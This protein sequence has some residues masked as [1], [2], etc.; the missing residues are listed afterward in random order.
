MTAIENLS[1]KRKNII[2]VGLTLSVLLAALDSTVVSTAMK[3]ISD[4]L[5]GLDLYTWPLTIYMLFSTIITPI[6]GK[7]ADTFGR[8]FFFMIGAVTFLGASAL[9]GVSQTMMQLIVFRG[10]QG[11][12]GGILMS[13]TFAMI[14]DIFPPEE[15]AKNTGIVFSAFGLASVIGPALGGTL[16]DHLG[17]RWVFYVN[18]PVGII[19]IAII[20]ATVPS[21]KHIHAARSKIDYMGTI[22]LVLGLTPMLFAFMW[23]GDKY[24]WSSVQIISLFAFSAALLVIFGL[25]EN[26]AKDPIIS[27]SLFKDRT[28]RISTASVFLSNATMLGAV[29]FIPLYVQVVL[30][31]SAT[32]SGMAELPM[33]LGFVVASFISGQAISKTGKLKVFGVAGFV[34]T[35]VGILILTV[36]GANSPFAMLVIGMLIAGVGIGINMP[37]FTLAVQNVF[38]QSKMGVVTAAVQFFRSIGGTIASAVFGT[39]MLSSI[40]SGLSKIDFLALTSS[41]P[42]I[43][44][45]AITKNPKLL[46]NVNTIELLKKSVPDSA[47]AV[48]NNLLTQIKNI[49]CISIHNVFITSL[50]IA[51][52]A[53]IISLFLPNL[54]IKNEKQKTSEISTSEEPVV[55]P[56][57]VNIDV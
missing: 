7:L 28:F 55:A 31:K 48:F 2:M 42:S 52:V 37:V 29:L 38:P 1:K 23:A 49:L 21:I 20:L 45:S 13:N 32:D 22:A 44:L 15:R 25:I 35:A 10:I 8:K 11:I 36:L 24:A 27:M 54:V 6:S 17:W 16:T 3:K 9:C 5:N 30:G 39:V 56:A 57:S 34:L 40:T 14:G 4:D 46:T 43:D 50:V 26:R 53:V 47:M 51:L 33:M 41:N 12:G 19:F 18:L